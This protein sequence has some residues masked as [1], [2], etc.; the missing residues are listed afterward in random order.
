MGCA[1]SGDGRVGLSASLD[2]TL[3]VWDLV[4][5]EQRHRL[6]VEADGRSVALHATAERRCWAMLAAT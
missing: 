3:I 2:T 1:I 6:A 4:S 5:G